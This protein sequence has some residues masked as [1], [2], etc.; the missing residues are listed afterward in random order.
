MPQQLRAAALKNYAEV[1]QQQGLNYLPLLHAAGLGMAM[2]ANP[3]QRIPA[4]AAIA[5]LEASAAQSGCQTFGLRMAESRQLS[6]FGIISLLLAHQPT[7]RDALKTTMQY[8]HLLNELLAIHV[9]DV[10]KTVIIREELI[11]ENPTTSRQAIELALGVLYRMCSALLG[12]HWNPYSIN[13]THAAPADLQVHRRLFRCKLE[14]SQEFN[15][16]ICSADDLDFPNPGFDPA[17]AEHV[18]RYMES[19]PPSEH[20][21]IA[22]EVRKAIFILMPMGRATIEQVARGLGLNVRT[23]QRRLEEVGASFSEL[24]N[25]VRS[26]LALRYMEN[27]QYSLERVGALLGFAMP[28]SF[29]RWFRAEFDIAPRQWRQQH[30]RSPRG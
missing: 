22:L 27:R 30:K 21:S 20:G 29:T 18:R 7:L 14:F 24:L 19:L 15:G 2:L 28:S 17:M 6:H 26:E 11:G 25:A 5:L 3:E 16:I 12:S 4:S 9:E 8:S 23:L 1:A 13:F 10:G